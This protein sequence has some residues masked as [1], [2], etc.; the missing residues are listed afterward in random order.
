MKQK[1]EKVALGILE[2]SKKLEPLSTEKLTLDKVNKIITKII[3]H[4]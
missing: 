3:N 1:E 4:I 2:R